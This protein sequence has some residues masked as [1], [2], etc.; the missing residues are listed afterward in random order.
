MKLKPSAGSYELIE[1]GV[2]DLDID[3]VTPEDPN[4]NFEDS[5]PQLKFVFNVSDQGEQ[6]A[7]VFAWTGQTYGPKSKLRP[8]LAVLLPDFDPDT[9][10]LET[11][12]LEGK[13][14]RGVVSVKKGQDGTDR[15][16]ITELLPRETRRRQAA[17]AAEPAQA[18]NVPF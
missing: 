2:Y 13:R 8:W 3:S 16:R 10:E 5:R 17:P 9:D 14:C 7:K 11:D 6:I 4:P 18:Q 12:V 1:A 15:N